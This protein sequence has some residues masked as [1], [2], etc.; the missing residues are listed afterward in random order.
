MLLALPFSLSAQTYLKWN[1][2]YWALGVINTSVETKL[3]DKLTFNADLVFSP[4]KSISGNVMLVGEL[5]PEVRYYH[6]G[7]FNGFYMGAY[8]GG[9]VFKMTKW[10]YINTGSYQ[11]GRGYAL[12]LST[13]YEISINNRWMLDIYVGYAFQH[14]WYRGYNKRTGER[15]VGLNKS[16]EWLPYKIGAAFS[17]G[18]WK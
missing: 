3:N 6:K 8:V 15:Y 14:S 1:S 12:G 17:Y 9:H 18:I 4:W 16:A 10:N 5:I 11:I 7:A 2:L 13:G